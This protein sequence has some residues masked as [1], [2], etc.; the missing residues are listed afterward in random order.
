MNARVKFL[1]DD[2]FA[3]GEARRGRGGHD[4][5]LAEAESR[6]HRA[7]VA[8]GRAEAAAETERRLAVALEQTAAA[9]G[10][11]AGGLQA[12]EARVEDEALQVAVTVARKLSGALV[13]RE[14]L[15][16]I[17]ALA[18]ECFRTLVT[19]PHVAVRV[20]DALYEEARTRLDALAGQSNFSGR[21]IVLA[22]P[23]L[24]AGDCRIEWADGGAVRNRS[25][26]EAA[27]T[28]A[29][30]RYLA[31]GRERLGANNAWSAGQ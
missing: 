29:V 9:L 5:S 31:A 6:G 10:K 19:A 1:F 27:V 15:A 12:I 25:A 28:A 7:G 8:A 18:T 4:A 17:E 21:L 3:S 24:A 16:E 26:V 30:E 20:G 22:D 2:D 23:E 14:P 13:A 11:L